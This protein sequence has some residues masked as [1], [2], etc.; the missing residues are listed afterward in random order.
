MKLTKD[1]LSTLLPELN[2]IQIRAIKQAFARE[3][4]AELELYYNSVPATGADAKKAD[5]HFDLRNAQL[6]KEME[7][8]GWN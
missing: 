8:Y 1:N 4:Q 6:I 5:E 2:I 3:R 7:N